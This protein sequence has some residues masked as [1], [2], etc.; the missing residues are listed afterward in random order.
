L[1]G[2][3]CAVTPRSN[4]I[5]KPPDHRAEVQAPDSGG[6]GGWFFAADPDRSF[7]EQTIFWAPEALPTIVPVRP[8]LL[9][10][11]HTYVRLDLGE[12]KD[13]QLQQGPDGW[14]AVLH[15]RGVEHRI[16]FKEAPLVAAT[17]TVEFPLDRDFEFRADAGRRLW[18][19]LNGRPQGAPLH[20][21]SAHRRRRV[22]LALRASDARRD[23]AT[24]RE[25]AEVL[26]PAQRIRERDWRT[27]EVRNHIIR[28]VKTGLALVQGG[29]RALLK[30]PSRK[31]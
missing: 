28:L 8:T 5:I 21:L 7:F 13:S 23:G 4:A 22:A 26:L 20:A 31:K 12:L 27:H 29:Y 25:I 3:A 9:V 24:Y 30:P 6:I 18:R 17:Y 14:H 10:G 11:S 19:G 1:R 16:W 15:L 2:S